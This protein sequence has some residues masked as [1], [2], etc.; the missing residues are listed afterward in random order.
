MATKKTHEQFVQELS[1]N[2]PKVKVLGRY[3]NAKTKVSV[4][5]TV[6]GS[7]WQSSPTNLS[8]G[9]GCPSCAGNTRKTH[10]QFITEL[11]SINPEIQI[12][13]TYRSRKTPILAQCKQCGE[14]WKP[15]PNNLLLGKGCPKCS[16]TAKSDTR[17]LI[18]RLESISLELEVLGEYK[19]NVTPI[20]CRCKKCTHVWKAKPAHLLRGHACPICGKKKQIESRRYTNDEFKEKLAEANPDIEMLGCYLGRHEKLSVRCIRCGNEWNPEAGSLL[21]GTGCPSCA[22]ISTSF[23]EQYILEA[24]RAALDNDSV[25]SRDKST[26]NMELDVYLP[27][28]KLAIEFGSWHWHKNKVDADAEKMK[29]CK[30]LGIQLVIIYDAYK[31]AQPPFPEGCFIFRD[32]LGKEGNV[33]FLKD[34][35]LL[36]LAPLAHLEGAISRIDW[37]E[38]K[39]RARRNSKRKTTVEYSEQLQR[40]NPLIHVEGEYKNDSSHI[41]V[42]CKR[43]G[44]AWSPSA[45]SLLQGHGCPKCA[46]RRRR[47]P[48]E[49]VEEMSAINPTLQVMG[50][51]TTRKNPVHTKCL[52]CRHEWNPSAN[53]LLQ[54]HGCPKCAA[55]A[56]GEKLSQ[57]ATLR[58]K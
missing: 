40:I 8:R 11:F 31:E 46:N 23:A 48:E 10:E 9:S 16:G 13:G 41:D 24:F 53:N 12:L 39:K 51:F 2:N 52:I 15:T 57:R 14:E 3:V 35:I 6:C 54:G 5:C 21:C 55:K 32:Y 56:A 27:N 22:T 1:L 45:G 26:I 44:Y 20:E 19:N 18:S 58:P 4:M 43:C 28:Q 33:N 7:T 30:D 17:T 49:F 29:R 38:V 37:T 36:E 25:L 34:L 50:T 42:S 47:T